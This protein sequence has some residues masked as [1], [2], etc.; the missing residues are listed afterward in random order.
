MET[1]KT[2]VQCYVS[3]A[4]KEWQ[5]ISSKFDSKV[6]K[7]GELLLEEDKVCNHLSFLE[8][9]LLHFFIWNDGEIKTKFFTEAPYIFTS[10]R[11]FNNRIPAKENIQAIENSI[12]WQVSYKDH[13]ELLKIPVWNT[14]AQKITQEVQFFTENIL[15]EL[16]NKTAEERY[17]LLLKNRSDLV[18]RVPLKYLASYL[19]ITPQSLSRIR[20]NI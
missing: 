7:K 13:Q 16:Q 6:Y 10:Q 14:L 12:V 19:G 17:S 1:F 8:S 20:R 3:L 11:S 5:I 2:F 4:P 15:E 9:G 18:K